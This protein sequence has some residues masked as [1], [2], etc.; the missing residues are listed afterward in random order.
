[1][2]EN[3]T[4]DMSRQEST[5]SRF[6]VSEEEYENLV[7][8]LKEYALSYAQKNGAEKW[9]LY[10]IQRHY[11]I[12]GVVSEMRHLENGQID[13]LTKLNELKPDLTWYRG[14]TRNTWQENM[15]MS[16]SS[17]YSPHELSTFVLDGGANGSL[18]RPE[19]INFLKLTP[20]RDPVVYTVRVDAL[21]EGLKQN[22]I[23]LVSQSSYD[24]R[25][26]PGENKKVYLDFC[27]KHLD[28]Q[29]AETDEKPEQ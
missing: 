20:R 2:P 5:P 27:R 6:E 23:V 4:T 3:Q 10:A 11:H 26:L 24:L 15:G 13:I 17:D 21:I 25:I 18:A 28:I 14:G 9:L 12:D 22:A 19:V 8:Q 16:I 1:M 7:D 29:D